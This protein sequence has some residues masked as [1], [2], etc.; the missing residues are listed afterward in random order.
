[1]I[2]YIGPPLRGKRNALPV[3]GDFPAAGAEKAAG[4][5]QATH[6]VLDVAGN[7]GSETRTR[8]IALLFLVQPFSQL[9]VDIVGRSVP[10]D[11]I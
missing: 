9:R 6:V 7:F 10:P 2:W 4:S 1:L 5:G 8:F 3:N 11:V